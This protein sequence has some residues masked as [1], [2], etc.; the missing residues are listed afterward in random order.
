MSTATSPVAR[1]TALLIDPILP[2]LV[3]L[4]VP[5]M[6]AM[7]ASALVAVAETIYVGRL[8]TEPLAGLALVFP[9]VM[10][11]GMLSAGAMGGGVS[12]AIA[13]SLGAGDEARASTLA[14]HALVIGCGA[15]LASMLLLLAFGPFIYAT[16]GGRG[17]PLAQAVLYS[18]TV[19]TGAMGIWLTNTLASIVRG[20]GNMRVPS[21]TLL[22]AALA[23]VVLGGGLSL[24]IGPF[25]RLGMT[26]IALGLVITQT[27]AALFL[28]GY[29][30]SGRGRVHL[31]FT[32]PTLSRGMFFDILRVGGLACLSPL[33][34]V[35]TVLIL[36]RLV[37]DF[38]VEALAGYGIG[39]RL[40]FLLIPIAFGVGVACV[41][42]V[43]MAIGARD[44]ARAR[45]VAWSGGL[46]AACLVGSVGLA[47]AIFPAA[48]ARLFTADPSVIDAARSYFAW[49][50]PCYGL[51]GLG[52]CLYFASQGAGKVFWPVIA[53]TLRLAVVIAGGAWLAAI[54]A[55]VWAVFALI[56]VGMATYGLATAAA[57][58]F[59][60]WGQS[61]HLSVDQTS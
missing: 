2:T 59:V 40:E 53:G 39:A 25:P 49:V 26:G 20:G 15:G 6:L 51:F 23:Q 11:M 3:R 30:M 19:F 45:A 41:P 37:A 5:N 12:S 36:T 29:L 32:N 21:V 48:W 9:L 7:V 43:G 55:P 28:L 46:M 1:P 17:E 47:V 22:L 14:L 52:L 8:G 13:R 44:V 60:P 50:G 35:L 38:G 42:M 33:Q 56:A 16:L 54:Q 18:N 10:L 58:Y 57:I 4:A 31:T 27:A 34:S 61:Q 24:G